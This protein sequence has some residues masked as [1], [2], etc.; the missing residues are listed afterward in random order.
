M[1]VCLSVC[2]YVSLPFCLSVS[3]YVLLS[4]CLSA[5]ISAIS[6]QQNMQCTERSSVG[7]QKCRVM[8][9]LNGSWQVVAELVFANLFTCWYY[10]LEMSSCSGSFIADWSAVLGGADVTRNLFGNTVLRNIVSH[11]RGPCTALCCA[12]VMWSAV[13]SS[14]VQCSAVKCS[15]VQCSAVQCSAVQYNAV[16]CSS[17]YCWS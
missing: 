10:Y 1:P 5:L 17:V 12:A 7:C 9:S 16:Q 11:R 4:V 2:L 15:A 13:K 6:H 3:L 14:A 8:P